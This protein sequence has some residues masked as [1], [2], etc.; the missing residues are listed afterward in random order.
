[1]YI[2]TDRHK[3]LTIEKCLFSL[4]TSLLCKAAIHAGVIADE[5]GGRIHVT[6]QKGASR[7]RGV[8]A[9]GI[10]SKA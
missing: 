4:Q 8:L 3:W 6:H 1:M 2:F 7:Y 5:L 9:N 10:F